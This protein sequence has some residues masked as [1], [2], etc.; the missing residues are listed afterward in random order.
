MPWFTFHFQDFA[1]SFLSVLLEAVPFLLLGSLLSGLVEVFVPAK[2]F[3]KI[4]PHGGLPAVLVSGL[5]G[6][7]LPICECGSVVVVRRLIR[8]GLPISCAVTYMLAAPI[9]SPVVALSTWMA[10]KGQDPGLMTF[11]RLGLG[12][13][14]AVMVGL[15]MLRIRT[16]RWVQP[17]LLAS[18]AQASRSAMKVAAAPSDLDT[19]ASASVW[20]RLNLAGRAAVSDF[21]DVALFLVIGVAIT[22]V[23]GTAVNQQILTPLATNSFLATPVLMLFAVVLALCSTSDAFI[24]ASLVQWPFV[25]KLAF[26]VYGPMFD[27]KLFFLYGVI[28]KRRGVI[29][30]ALGLFIA[31]ALICTRLEVLRP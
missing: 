4:M 29:V 30:L 3:Q 24:A 17:A 31:V 22:S 2:W 20:G 5:L 25:S 8:K 23:F 10:F 1:F 12:Y 14:L 18:A 13:G 16:E 21:L 7:L 15:I 28:F 19:L 9:V 11:L 26:L 6:A 27:L